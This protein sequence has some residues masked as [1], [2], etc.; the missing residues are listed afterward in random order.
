MYESISVY[1][2][3][4]SASSFFVSKFGVIRTFF[5]LPDNEVNAMSRSHPL[6]SQLFPPYAAALCGGAGLLLLLLALC[7]TAG[8]SDAPSR[9]P[10]GLCLVLLCALAAGLLFYEDR[11]PGAALFSLLPIGLALF[12]RALCLEHVTYDYRDFLSGWASFFRENGGWAAVALPK[13]NYN[14]PYLYFL[15]AI[16]YLPVRDLYLIKLFSMLFDVLL[17]W[18]GYRLVHRLSVP[19]SYRPCAA[20]CILLLLPTV[21]LNG[22]YWAQCDSIYGALCLHA[23]SSALDRC[24]VGSVVLLALAFSFKLQTVFLV[25]LWGALWFAGRVRFRDLL[26]FPATYV[27]T[28]VPA[29]F[30]GKPLGDILGVYFGQA[31]EYS[32]YLT[33]NAPSLYAL[34]PYGAEVDTTLAARLGILAAFLFTV[35]IL[36]WLL[37]RRDRLTDRALFTAGAAF[38]VGIPLLLPHMHDRYFFLADT[39]TLCWACLDRRRGIPAAILVQIASLGAY[40]AYLMLRYAF[41]MA[42]GSLML[43]ATLIWTLFCLYQEWRHG[44]GGPVRRRRPPAV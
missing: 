2:V 19:G 30:L 16:S 39:I 1:H 10:V 5:F 20:F 12:L 33:L 35:G 23:L 13:G 29:L 11:R 36:L 3:D 40:H 15:A 27:L 21:A 25:P 34:I 32:D 4:F 37:L 42:W 8:L 22:A 9:L 18:G 28:I 31:A 24:P 41:P 14:V 17:A 26:L 44:E 43:L 6:Q 38:A 7:R